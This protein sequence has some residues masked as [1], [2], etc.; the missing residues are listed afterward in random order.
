MPETTTDEAMFRMRLK[1]FIP[2][3]LF[4]TAVISGGAG[5][6][7]NLNSNTSDITQTNDQVV[8]NNERTDRKVSHVKDDV[9]KDVTIILLE[10]D[11]KALEIELKECKDGI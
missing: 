1:S 8:Y 6:I 7:A 4:Y 9:I 2:A 11:V 5:M 10:R 3:V